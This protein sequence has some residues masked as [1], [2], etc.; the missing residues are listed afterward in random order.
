MDLKLY[1]PV[2]EGKLPAFIKNSN[3]VN[4]T[5]PFTMNPV[6]SNGDVKG[7]YITIKSMSGL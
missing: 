4:I 7:F 3:G 6:V 2:I 5:I 1:P